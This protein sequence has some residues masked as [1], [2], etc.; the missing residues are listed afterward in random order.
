MQIYEKKIKKHTPV[1]TFLLS[2]KLTSIFLINE[3]MLITEIDNFV[4]LFVK[5]LRTNKKLSQNDIAQI[6]GTTKS[7]VGNVEST[8]NRAK[9]NLDH[10]NRLA[11]YFGLSP[12]EFLPEVPFPAD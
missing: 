10:I 6:I 1:C 8:K 12:R 7:F 11:D 9:Y 5:E 3:I 4:I 2:D